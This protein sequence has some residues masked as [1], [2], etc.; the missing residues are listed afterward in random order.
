MVDCTIGADWAGRSFENATNYPIDS[1]RERRSIASLANPSSTIDTTRPSVLDHTVRRVT[2]L[3]HSSFLPPTSS[4]PHLRLSSCGDPRS[5]PLSSPQPGRMSRKNA[6]IC[7]LLVRARHPTSSR[8]T[9]P[10][11]PFP[12]FVR[13][14]PASCGMKC[15]VPAL[16]GACPSN[17]TLCL[18]K[19]SAVVQAVGSCV[20]QAC[21]VQDERDTT[22][23]YMLDVCKS[24]VRQPPCPAHFQSM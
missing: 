6:K 7:P 20:I 2:T 22:I 11:D 14:P 15:L 23:R 17:D 21:T 12:L 4:L 19:T 9:P 3:V 5:R 8:P 16:Y 13:P 10:T 1:E 24:F 18:C